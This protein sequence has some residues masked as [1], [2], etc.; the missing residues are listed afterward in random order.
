MSLLEDQS[1]R[2]LPIGEAHEDV[3]WLPIL[4]RNYVFLRRD[5]T[6][7]IVEVV[8]MKPDGHAVFPRR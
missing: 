8:L 5:Q 7:T 4:P 6:G 3:F 2:L 1:A